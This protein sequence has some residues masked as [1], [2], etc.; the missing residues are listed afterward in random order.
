MKKTR[1]SDA[2]RSNETT[3][4]LIIQF[5]SLFISVYA[6]ADKVTN[7]DKRM[8]VFKTK[9]KF[10][11]KYI[12]RILFR[13]CEIIGNLLLFL[14]IGVFYG[15]FWAFAYV[16]YL[17]IVHFI[18]FKNGL[19]GNY[20]SNTISYCIACMNLGL[21]VKHNTEENI[22]THSKTSC[23]PSKVSQFLIKI[24]YFNCFYHLL[25]KNKLYLKFSRYLSFYYLMARNLQGLILVLMT[26]GLYFGTMNS[27]FDCFFFCASPESRYANKRL[28]IAFLY[29]DLVCFVFLY[30]CFCLTC[31]ILL[32]VWF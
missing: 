4:V 10:Y 17:W 25:R 14:I 1:Q 27:R 31:F 32:L 18:L 30:L 23:I 29:I 12:L 21:T 9:S 19:L 7:D 13:L 8:F 5:I 16:C 26:I 24:T 20:V 28:F 6:I 15:A 2:D 11:Y 3:G 22:Q